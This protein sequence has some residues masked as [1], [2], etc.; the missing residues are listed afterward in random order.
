MPVTEPEVPTVAMPVAPLLHTP[1]M[2]GSVRLVEVPVHTIAPAGEIAD[3]VGKT[4]T[5]AKTWQLPT[6]YVIGAMPALTP[7]TVPEMEPI[8][9]T[10]VLPLVHVPPE[11]KLVRLVVEPAHT[12]VVDGAIAEGV[13]ITVTGFTA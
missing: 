13:L 2:V 3:G 7:V 6:V 1:P 12:V 10:P 9:A 8:A 4:E 11:V 5:V